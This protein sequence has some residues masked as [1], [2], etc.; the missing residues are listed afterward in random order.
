MIELIIL[1][2]NMFTLTLEKHIIF[3]DSVKGI[4]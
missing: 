4:F 3:L 1:D 2:V